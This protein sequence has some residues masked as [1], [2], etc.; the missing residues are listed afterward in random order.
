VLSTQFIEFEKIVEIHEVGEE[1][2]LFLAIAAK[3][4]T[5]EL[6]HRSNDRPIDEVQPH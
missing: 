1:K 2:A 5:Y 3:V 6:D 4:L